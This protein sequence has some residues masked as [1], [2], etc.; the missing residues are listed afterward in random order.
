MA[1]GALL[2]SR[3]VADSS[4]TWLDATAQADLVRTGQASP[5]ELVEAAIARIGAL[6]PRLDAVVRTR[7]EQ[8]REEA[9]G[10]LPD[11]PFR[12][13]PFLLKDLGA[14]VAGEPTVVRDRS[15]GVRRRCRSTSFLAEQFRAAGF[16]AWDARRC[17]S[18]GRP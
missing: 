11:G 8:A 6:N 9:R 18:S 12:G 15:D 10:H 16:I 17:R 2:A 4:L 3:P 14:T 5:T 13:V 7:F 1:D